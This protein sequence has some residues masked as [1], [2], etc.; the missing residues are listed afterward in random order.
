MA[1]GLKKFGSSDPSDKA[2]MFHAVTAPG[3][4]WKEGVSLS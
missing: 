4:V 2:V 1:I 3:W